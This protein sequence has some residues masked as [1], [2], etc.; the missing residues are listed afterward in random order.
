LIENGV[1][2]R[3][4]DGSNA[5]NLGGILRWCIDHPDRRREM[6]MAARKTILE[7]WSPEVAATRLVQLVEALEKR[8]PS[9]FRDEGP[10]SP[11]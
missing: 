6:G 7:L 9:P 8:E 3:T 1:N 10:C 5:E 4:F 11:V 2:G